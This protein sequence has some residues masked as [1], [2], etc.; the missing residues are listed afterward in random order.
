MTEVE[1]HKQP[2][3]LDP[4]KEPPDAEAPL[5]QGHSRENAEGVV[6]AF[7]EHKAAVEAEAEQ[8]EVTAREPGDHA[9]D[10]DDEASESEVPSGS[11]DTVMAWV[12]DD[13]ERARQAL[14][15]ERAGQ[16]RTTLI[17]KLEAIAA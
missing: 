11:A 9:G 1:Y 6:E 17:A 14:E 10:S 13:P 4:T 16:Q 15:A 5:A 3:T 8:P 2:V 12:G 7:E